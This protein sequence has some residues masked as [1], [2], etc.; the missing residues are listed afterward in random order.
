M[1]RM[2]G[3]QQGA[4]SR[5]YR[6]LSGVMS[7]SCILIVVMIWVFTSIKIHW[8]CRLKR[9]TYYYISIILKKVDFFYFKKG[10]KGN[11]PAIA[12]K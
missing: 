2:E 11:P 10:A 9:D 1:L 5:R 12:V 7:M 8:N 3:Q 4:T 6:E